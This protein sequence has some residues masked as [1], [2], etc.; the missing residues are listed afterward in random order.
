M[1]CFCQPGERQ[2]LSCGAGWGPLWTVPSGSGPAPPP[3][4]AT[5]RGQR[6]PR[7]TVGMT[8]GPPGWDRVCGGTAN[9]SSVAASPL[10]P[11]NVVRPKPSPPPRLARGR[12]CRRTPAGDRGSR[13]TWPAVE[14][15]TL[16][17]HSLPGLLSQTQRERAVRPSVFAPPRRPDALPHDT[18]RRRRGVVVGFG[19]VQ[20]R[21]QG[22]HDGTGCV[23]GTRRICAFRAQAYATRCLLGAVR[24]PQQPREVAAGV[25][26][27]CRGG[28]GLGATQL[29]SLQTCGLNA[30]QCHLYEVP[31]ALGLVETEVGWWLR[32]A[33]RRGGARGRGV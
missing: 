27:L 23:T 14:P 22:A 15:W 25:T 28:A 9:P 12:L 17:T 1:L 13:A 18:G 4:T 3:P 8:R 5:V 30:V 16:D 33:G 29:W 6:A 26:A 7:V 19:S 20:A 11:T 10:I 31:K 32:G 21:A 2:R 24:D